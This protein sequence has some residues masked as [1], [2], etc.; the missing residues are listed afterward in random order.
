MG[1]TRRS[2]VEVVVAADFD[3]VSHARTSAATA[4][5]RTQR[6]ET[7]RRQREVEID[8]ESGCLTAQVAVVTNSFT[9]VTYPAV[10]LY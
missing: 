6:R 8:C 7:W 1:A 10:H 9:G 5:R 2:Q 4:E 3:L